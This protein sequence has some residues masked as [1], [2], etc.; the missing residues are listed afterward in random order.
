VYIGSTQGGNDL[1]NE[2]CEFAGAYSFEFTAAS[3]TSWIRYEVTIGSGGSIKVDNVSVKAASSAAYEGGGLNQL[4]SGIAANHELIWDVLKTLAYIRDPR[5]T[6]ILDDLEREYGIYPNLIL[7]EQVRRDKLAAVK[8]ARVGTGS[9][10]NLQNALHTAG[11]TNLFVWENSPAQDPAIFFGGALLYCTEFEP[12]FVVVASAGTGNRAMI[13]PD[14]INWT[15]HSAPDGAWRSVCYGTPTGS[16]DGLYVAVATAGAQRAMKST[17]GVNWVYSAIPEQNWRG[18]CWGGGLYV[19]VATSGTGNRVA[20][21]PNGIEWTSR[22]SAEDNNWWDVCYGTPSGSGLYV[23]VSST[24]TNRV[25]T[26]PDAI[27][28]TSRSVPGLAWR[29]VCY[30]TPSGSGLF[31]AVSAG[32][33]SQV[34]TSPDGVTW[35]SRTTPN[36]QWQSVCWGNNLYVAVSSTGTGDRVMTSP[37]GITWTSR[38]TPD[39]DWYDVHYRAGLFVA[40]ASTG[41]GDRVMTSPDGI[42]WTLRSSAEDSDWDGITSGQPFG[43][44]GEPWAQCGWFQGE[45][46]VNGDIYTFTIDFVAECGETLSQ[47]DEPT[48]L[49]GNFTGTT[50]TKIEY[51]IPTDP[52][53]WPLVFFVG[54]DATFNPDTGASIY[55]D[56]TLAQCDEPVAFCQWFEGQLKDIEFVDVPFSRRADLV[57]LILQIKPIHSWCALLVNYT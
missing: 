41:T 26:S 53:D 6:P 2:S 22:A 28:W 55:C 36:N 42:T 52:I 44:C 34:I 12:T 25:M 15:D 39:R 57:R 32:G 45:L 18:V 24:G 51:P 1:L 31:V 43:Q 54:G 8:Y 33:T 37:D 20:T 35:T 13:S 14:G 46:I 9:K 10:D 17:D 50:R 49:A 29:G 47:C 5:Q 16:L 7:T 3:P 19:A 21:S 11:F 30:G 40:V 4:L 38:T 56:D 48:A 27:T 23:A